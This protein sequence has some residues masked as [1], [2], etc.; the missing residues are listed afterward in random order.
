MAKPLSEDLPSRLIAAV[1]GGRSRRGAAERFGVS[2]AS[3]IRWPREVVS[4]DVVRD[5]QRLGCVAKPLAERPGRPRRCSGNARPWLYGLTLQKGEAETRRKA[6]APH[7]PPD[8]SSTSAGGGPPGRA[9]SSPAS[10]PR[11]ARARGEA[12]ERRPRAGSASSSPTMVQARPGPPHRG[13]SR[14]ALPNSTAGPGAGSTIRAV[15]SLA[16]R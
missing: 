11:S 6:A 10:A 5:G 13:R 3:A 2:V 7:P 8:N 9:T 16:R 12:R 14:T 15:A 4:P 1:E